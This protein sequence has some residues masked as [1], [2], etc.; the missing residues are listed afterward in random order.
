MN[1]FKDFQIQPISKSFDGDKISIERIVGREIQVLAFK[2]EPSK[3]KENTDYLT[4]QI[5]IGEFKHIVFTGS[6]VLMSMIKQ[7][8]STG[9]PFKTTIVKENGGFKFT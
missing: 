9:F 7:V 8:P 6:T 1:S 3:K 5:L 4:L 2:I